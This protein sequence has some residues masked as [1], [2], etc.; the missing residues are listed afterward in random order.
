MKNDLSQPAGA[1]AQVPQPVATALRSDGQETRCRLLDA[2]MAL[3]AGKGFSKTSTRE[4]ASAAQVNVASISYYFGDKAGLY[5]AVFD[6]PRSKHHTDTALYNQPGMALRQSLRTVMAGFTEPL[7]QGDLV[8]SC[9]KLHYREMLEPTGMWRAEID[10]NIKPAHQALVEVLCRHMGV[11]QVDDDIH[12]LAFS[13][14]G[15]G[16]LLHMGGDVFQAIRPELIESPVAIDR[17]CD[18]LVDFAV[19][20]VAGEVQRRSPAQTLQPSGLLSEPAQPAQTAQPST[21]LPAL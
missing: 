6:D 20:L 1:V 15:L 7:K 11:T 21:P 10:N 13:I 17:Y 8:Q 16:V 5:R 4:I 9:M 19:D 2:A 14:A 3:F 18:R 12:R